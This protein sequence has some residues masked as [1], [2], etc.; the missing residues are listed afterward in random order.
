MKLRKEMDLLAQTSGLLGIGIGMFV[1]L[2]VIGICIISY[3]LV[4]GIVLLVFGG[5]II[6]ASVGINRWL[7]RPIYAGVRTAIGIY[8]H[9]FINK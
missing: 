1:T 2:I 9:E 5:I 4:F 6:L 3:N 8:E 7:F